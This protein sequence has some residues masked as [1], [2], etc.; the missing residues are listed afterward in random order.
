M[1]KVFLATSVHPW[2][3]IR[4]LRKE[5]VS[6]A[7]RYQVELHAPAPFD[8]R[9]YEGVRIHGLPQW[10]R[11]SDR[12]AIRR[13]LRRRVRLSDAEIFHFH[14]PELIPLGL[15]VKLVYKKRVIYDIHEDYPAYFR[16]KGWIPWPLRGLVAAAFRYIERLACRFFDHLITTSPAIDGNFARFPTTMVS[17]YPRLEAD[18]AFPEKAKGPLAFVYAGSMEEIRGIRELGQAFLRIVAQTATPVRLHIAGQLRG[19]EQFQQEVQA[20]FQHPSVQY[21]GVLPF[22]AAMALMRS[23]HVGV[24]PFLPLTCNVNIVPHK[25]FDYMA[26]GLVILASDFNG[27][28]RN[29]LEWDIGLL[30]DPTKQESIDRQLIAAATAGERL[31]RMGK[32]AFRLVRE[33]FTWASQ[34]EQLFQAFDA[35][36]SAS[37]GELSVSSRR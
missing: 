20:I 24:I 22:E 29:L 15:L 2:D 7:Q 10:E 3:D 36:V 35:V 11:V 26:A 13:E 19:S 33:R 4:V 12:R 30:F 21:H 37:P 17:N 31:E 18:G 8:Y 25:L 32:R 9:E 1:P 5:G 6:L 16:H 14:D 27:W 28:P 34:E 23:C